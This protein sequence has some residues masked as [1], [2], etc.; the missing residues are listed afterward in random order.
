MSCCPRPSPSPVRLVTHHQSSESELQTANRPAAGLVEQSILGEVYV[1]FLPGSGHSSSLSTVQSSLFCPEGRNQS[2][3]KST[4]ST[5][6]YW[7]KRLA[8][9]K[10]KRKMQEAAASLFGPES[11]IKSLSGFEV[12]LLIYFHLDCFIWKKMPSSGHCYFRWSK[13]GNPSRGGG[14]CG[15]INPQDMTFQ[16]D[17]LWKRIKIF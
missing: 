12:I 14:W 8:D 9:P 15:G 1:G 10:A 6:I 17:C 3:H 2:H 5:F 16:Q 7:E 4:C 13:G 11:M